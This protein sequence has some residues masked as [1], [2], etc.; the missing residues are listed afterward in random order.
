M[1]LFYILTKQIMF[2]QEIRN[3]MKDYQKSFQWR[4]DLE[5]IRAMDITS[6]EWR[7][8]LILELMQYANAFKMDYFIEWENVADISDIKKLLIQ[9]QSYV[10]NSLVVWA[11]MK[12]I[13]E[14]LSYEIIREHNWRFDF[15]IIPEILDW[16]KDVKDFLKISYKKNITNT[17]FRFKWKWGKE[18]SWKGIT[19]LAKLKAVEVEDI[20]SNLTSDKPESQKA[21]NFFNNKDNAD[22]IKKFW[23]IRA[24]WLS[25][26]TEYLS[27]EKGRFT[28][29]VESLENKTEQKEDKLINELAVVPEDFPDE[30]TTEENLGNTKWQEDK[31]DWTDSIIETQT[32]WITTEESEDIADNTAP[33]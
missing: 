6:I 3:Q 24:A 31:A 15:S 30:E 32:E 13:M 2:L 18:Y 7:T 27:W 21:I 17:L 5:R 20:I 19:E 11:K 4:T 23:Q 26:L 9:C 25:I 29:Y 1:I 8:S 28:L 22:I 33:F 16:A 10:D 12:L 14:K